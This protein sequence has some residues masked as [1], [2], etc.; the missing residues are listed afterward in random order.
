MHD[1]LF[2]KI[3]AGDIP[4][5]IVYSDDDMLVFKDIKPVAQHHLLLIPKKHIATLNDINVQD[6]Q[7]V[8][9]MLLK[10][11]DLAAQSEIEQDGYR[12]VINCNK[13]G[14]QDVYHLHIHLLGG[15]A[16]TWPP[17]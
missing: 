1:C 12:T 8:A 15:R 9:R 14:G 13:A 7:L 5:D 3:I 17:G 6:S 11:T 4:A 2:C 16:F 10:L